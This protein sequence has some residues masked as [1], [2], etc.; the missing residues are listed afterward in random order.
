V[1]CATQKEVRGGSARQGRRNTKAS[2]PV[3]EDDDLSFSFGGRHNRGLF[4]RW[5]GVV[6]LRRGGGV[7]RMSQL[8][9]RSIAGLWRS[10]NG[11]GGVGKGG[12]TCSLRWMTARTGA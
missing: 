8:R 9:Q 11:N 3:G 5:P 6:R 2:S 10:R 1:A 12:S 7:A 4:R